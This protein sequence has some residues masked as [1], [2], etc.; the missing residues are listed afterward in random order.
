MIDYRLDAD[1]VATITWNMPERSTNVLNEASMAAY[2]ALAIKAA[3]DPDV[4]GVIV[5][6][7]KPDFVAGADLEMLQRYADGAIDTPGEFYDRALAPTSFNGALRK[8]ETAGKPVVAAIN[9]TALGGG[10]EICL[11][12]HHRIVADDANI[13]IG[14][15]EVTLGLLPAGGGTQRLGRMLGWRKAAD[16]LLSGA[17]LTPREALEA[18]FVDDVVAPEVLIGAAKAWIAAHPSSQQ[19]WDAIGYRAPGNDPYDAGS[20]ANAI[21]TRVHTQSQGQ[22]PAQRAILTCLHDGLRASFAAG[23]LVECRELY[24]LLKDPAAGNMIR[25]MFFNMQRARK[26]ERRPCDVPVRKFE[27]VAVLGAGIMGAGI[28]LVAAESGARVILLDRTLETVAKGKAYCERALGKRLG[29]GAITQ[30]HHDEVLNRIA[31]TTEYALLE[32][33]DLCIEAV[34]EDRAVK[35]DVTKAAEQNIRPDA[36][37]GTNTSTLPISG[38]A[39]ASLRP[40]QFIG[41]HFFS[42]VDRMQLVEVIRGVRTSETSLAQAL[43]FVK[44]IGKIPIVVNDARGF[45]TSRVFGTYSREGAAMLLEGVAPALIENLGRSTGMP[46]APLALLDEIS[47]D[48]VAGVRR[49]TAEDLKEAFLREPLDDVVDIMVDRLDRVGRK[50]GRGFYDYSSTSKQLWPEL[51]RHFPV[52]A[53][54]SDH[55]E[56]RRRFLFIQAIET[57]RCVDEGVITDAGDADIGAILG[58]GF[59]QHLGG[60]LSLIDT[61]GV[62]SFVAQC[63]MLAQKY[64]PRFSPPQI[65]RDMA[66]TGAPF[67]AKQKAGAAA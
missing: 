1:G 60:P 52:K 61:I 13:R 45:Y 15:P 40:E 10:F 30:T 42:P 65:L 41:L 34:F 29:K 25:S 63:D 43:D 67:H 46:V 8:L 9:G 48:L 17:R 5:T 11:A 26:L 51:Q 53:V 16:F 35:A 24:A 31:P 23:Q 49:Q 3:L 56:L 47:L 37:F 18:K 57:A 27:K 7:A 20:D 62:Q 28:A 19:R 2:A 66:R 64:G 54:E 22:S 32:G 44:Q 21:I 36:L 6:S 14:L 55:E 38:L 59:P 58:W 4:K 12:C 50:T 33:C 39:E